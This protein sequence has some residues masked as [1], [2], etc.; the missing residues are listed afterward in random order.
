MKW[1]WFY[2]FIAVFWLALAVCLGLGLLPKQGGGHYQSTLL[3]GLALLMFLW[4]L[5]RIRLISMRRRE[6]RQ[7]PLPPANTTGESDDS[8]ASSSHR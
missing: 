3:A 5:V 7:A 8:P 6:K 4:N 1:I 2:S